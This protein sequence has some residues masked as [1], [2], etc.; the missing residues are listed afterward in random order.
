MG[1]L[2]YSIVYYYA[3]QSDI[4]DEKVKKGKGSL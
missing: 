4:F 1:C 3:A 2:N